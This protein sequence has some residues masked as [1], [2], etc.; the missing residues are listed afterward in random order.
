VDMTVQKEWKFRERYSAQF[1]A[2]FFNLLNRA[3]FSGGGGNPASGG[4]FNCSC[5]TPDTAGTN[6]VLGSG[7]ARAIQ[8][9]L[10]LAF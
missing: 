8:F 2:E 9:G 10:K 5:S 4:Q 6:Q 7:G 1:R 3:D